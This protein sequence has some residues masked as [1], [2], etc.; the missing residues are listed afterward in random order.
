MKFAII[1]DV[2][3]DIPHTPPNDGIVLY[4]FVLEN[5]LQNILELGF[6]HGV[7]TLYMAAA[8]DEI[9]YG[10]ITTI[11]NLTAKQAS[12]TLIELAEQIGLNQYINPIFANSSYNWELMKIIENNKSKHSDI[13]DF[14]FIDGAH[15]WETDG[16]AFF[17]VDKIL[18]EGSYILFDDIDWTFAKSK[19]L[20]GSN[21][22]K[23]MAEDEKNRPQIELVLKYLVAQHQD[24]EISSI[25]NRWAWVRKV[26]TNSNTVSFDQ[27]YLNQSIGQDC[28]NLIK[29]ILLKIKN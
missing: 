9:G 23:A 2:L 7:S 15:S 6:Q 8:L 26:G 4:N 13:F 19:G 18:K 3:K 5:K 27:L 17:L 29:K 21:F 11:D 28:Y 22:V 20:S 14:C 24:Y 16:F 12:P 25:K 10:T 1:K